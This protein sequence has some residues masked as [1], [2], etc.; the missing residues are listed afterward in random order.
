MESEKLLN[1]GDKV[2]I[3]H[4]CQRSLK[5]EIHIEAVITKV[6]DA[7]RIRVDSEFQKNQIVYIKDIK[8]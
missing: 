3:V 6:G 5:G 1:V 2:T 7:T 8:C 4:I